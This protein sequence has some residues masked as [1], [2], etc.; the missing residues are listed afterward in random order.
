MTH[1]CTECGRPMVLVR[2]LP[3]PNSRSP[4]GAFYCRP[5]GFAD[6]V[7]LDDEPMLTP[8]AAPAA[9]A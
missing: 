9:R 5:C 8:V 1:R 7:A 4:L 3:S 6:T 2:V